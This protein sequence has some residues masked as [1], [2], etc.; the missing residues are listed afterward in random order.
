VTSSLSI[1]GYVLLKQP[2][3][4]GRTAHVYKAVALDSGTAAAIKVLTTSVEPT[5]FLDEAFIPLS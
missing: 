3:A 5:S 1:P 4:T 2:P